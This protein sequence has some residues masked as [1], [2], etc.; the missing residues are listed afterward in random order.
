MKLIQSSA[1]E[2]YQQRFHALFP[3][4]PINE[5]PLD[6]DQ[7]TQRIFPIE[8]RQLH[9]TVLIMAVRRTTPT[10]GRWQSMSPRSTIMVIQW[11]LI[12]VGGVSLFP[13]VSPRSV[14]LFVKR[15]RVSSS[16]FS[17]RNPFPMILR[18]NLMRFPLWSR[19]ASGSHVVL[20]L[21]SCTTSSNRLSTSSIRVSIW[22]SI[23][24]SAMAP[25]S[26]RTRL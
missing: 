22:F 4:N 2:S 18:L 5:I 23:A 16:P 26:L 6:S 25:H 21:I 1:F 3:F 8:H 7:P 19:S 20:P 11:T 14:T 10:R 17:S 15:R 12:S 9:L 13:V 24:T